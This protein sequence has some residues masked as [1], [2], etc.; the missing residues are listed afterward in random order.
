MKK[1]FLFVVAVLVFS[2]TGCAQNDPAANIT[3]EQ[4]KEKIKNDSLLVILDVRTAQELSGPLGKLDGIIHIPIQE[5][6]SRIGELEQYKDKEIAVIC[7]TGNRSST[8]TSILRK[9]GFNAKNVQGGMV[10][11]RNS[12]KK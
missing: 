5:I 6:G 2:Y 10:Q 11:Y 12:E 9:E 1:V 7:R 8:V 4:L 3:I